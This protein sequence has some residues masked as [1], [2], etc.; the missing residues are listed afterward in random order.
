VTIAAVGITFTLIAAACSDKKDDTLEGDGTDPA[1]ASTAPGGPAVTDPSGTDPSATDPSD[2]DVPS[3]GDTAPPDTTAATPAEPVQP[4]GTLV[5][6]VEAETGSPWTPSAM[7]CD[8]SCQM[9][10]RT[11]YDPLMAVT[12]DLEIEGYLAESMEPNDDFTVW[13]ITL[14]DGITFHDGTPLDADA[15]IYNLNEAKNSLLLQPALRDLA[16]TA[17]AD[18]RLELAIEKLGPL[19]FTIATGKDGD[20]NTPVPWPQLP[21]FLSGQPGLIGSPTWLEAVK[22]GSAEPTAAVGTGPFVLTQY[23]P[24]DRLIVERNPDYWLTD[25][26]GNQLPYLD[27]IEFRVIPDSQIMGQA[28]RGGDLDL[29][30]TSDSGVVR[31][32][33]GDES[34]P[35]ILQDEYAET[36]YLLFH[37]TAPPLDSK[38]VRCALDQAIDKQDL[39]D[40]VYDGLG[41]V[42]NGPF[43]PGQ[44]GYLE[45]NGSLEYDPAAA[46]AA[47]ETYEAA[48]GPV[49]FIFDTTTSATNA[50]RADYLQRV[51]GEIG[52]DININQTEQSEFIVNALLGDPAFNAFGWRNHAGLYV[53]TQTHWWYG[54]GVTDGTPQLNFGRVSD[55][56]INDLLEKQRSELDPDVRRQY[57]E[58]INRQFASECWIVPLQYTVWGI[59][60]EPTIEGIG[61]APHAAGGFLRDG[62]GFPGQ[63]W[64]SAVHLSN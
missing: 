42:A 55:P 2:A 14:R 33:E 37:L 46:A 27:S 51:W 63:V 61:S 7:Q 3:T 64:M 23:A 19:S 38:E 44:E 12:E 54:E 16:A 48:N 39:I 24:G 17:N 40:V 35:T 6:G 8:S 10:S 47:I 20:I 58:D 13:T 4:G 32:F 1:P 34:F 25:E 43:S 22:A 60:G 45:D 31:S 62:A 59:I 53:D 18:G 15:V 56:V 29:M 57:A 5:V 36:N 30:A 50:A 41:E 11:F 52:V 21:Y 28:L 26:A 9:R 49:E